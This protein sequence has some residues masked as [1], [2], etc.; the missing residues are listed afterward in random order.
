MEATGVGI[1]T[2]IS[3]DIMEVFTDII[4]LTTIIALT[5]QA[6]IMLLVQQRA[7]V[8]APVQVLHLKG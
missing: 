7:P 5:E 8:D 3:M 2:V 6:I 1:G 4:L